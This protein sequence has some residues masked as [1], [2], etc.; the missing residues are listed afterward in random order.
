LTDDSSEGVVGFPSETKNLRLTIRPVNGRA[1][2]EISNVLTTS[3]DA[4]CRRQ[5]GWFTSLGGQSP[6]TPSGC[7][8]IFHG[9]IT[10][11]RAGG[12]NEECSN[13]ASSIKV[14]CASADDCRPQRISFVVDDV[15]DVTLFHTIPSVS[16]EDGSISFTTFPDAAG[17]SSVYMRIIDD[18]GSNEAPYA[19]ATPQVACDRMSD[20]PCGPG[21]G[22]ATTRETLGFDTSQPVEFKVR[23]LPVNDPPSITLK[24][25]VRCL[26]A[27]QGREMCVCPVQSDGLMSTANCIDREEVEDEEHVIGPRNMTTVHVLENAGPQFIDAFA[28]DV[29]TSSAVVGGLSVFAFTNESDGSVRYRMR[30]KHPILGRAGLEMAVDYAMSPGQENVYTADFELASISVLDHSGGDG[31]VKFLDR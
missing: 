10:N 7:M 3:E 2:F 29:S 17:E 20:L 5:L 19:G 16:A 18:F 28:T 25:D 22:P 4:H 15:S 31:A 14:P 1:S 27:R 21:T 26:D 12:D 13:C 9:A 23:I 8:Q 24:R 11:V 6:D 30:R